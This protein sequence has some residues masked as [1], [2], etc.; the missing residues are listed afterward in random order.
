MRGLISLALVAS[1]FVAC[2]SRDT[3]ANL[4]AA[5]EKR[6]TCNYSIYPPKECP[7]GFSCVTPEGLYGADGVCQPVAGDVGAACNYSVF[8]HKECQ[9]GLTCVTPERVYGA[10]GKCQDLGAPLGG[11]CNDSIY[12]PKSCKRGLDCVTPAGVYGASGKCQK[13]AAPNDN[14]PS[15]NAGEEGAECNYSIYPPKACKEGLTCK[16]PEGIF[17]ASGKCAKE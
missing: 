1:A 3:G 16:T 17:G 7:Q 10:D 8:P 13:A 9:Q 6:V 5:S 11:E 14:S 2:K 4:A 12:P 15:S